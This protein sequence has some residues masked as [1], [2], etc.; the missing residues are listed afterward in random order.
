MSCWGI[1]WQMNPGELTC[2]S[3]CPVE[4]HQF[5]KASLRRIPS[6]VK[7]FTN[8]S[9]PYQVVIG[10][11]ANKG[12]QGKYNKEFTDRTHVP[13]GDKSRQKCRKGQVDQVKPVG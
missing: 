8:K 11:P 3:N 13:A 6:P 10:D 9:I 12:R 7:E 1:Y 5:F 4:G 2:I